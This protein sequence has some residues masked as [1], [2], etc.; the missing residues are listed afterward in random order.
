M[1]MCHV[2]CSQMIMFRLNQTIK[3][4][5]DFFTTIQQAGQLHM[6]IMN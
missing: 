2:S 4:I 6:I 5:P 1:H 3:M